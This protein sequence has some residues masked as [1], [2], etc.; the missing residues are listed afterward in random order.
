MC[1]F[2]GLFIGRKGHLWRGTPKRSSYEDR[3]IGSV[4]YAVQDREII[5]FGAVV[6]APPWATPRFIDAAFE[7][8]YWMRH[9]YLPFINNPR[10]SDIFLLSAIIT[11]LSSYSRVQIP[12]EMFQGWIYGFDT[13]Q[14]H[15]PYLFAC[16]A[17]TQ[18]QVSEG[19]SFFFVSYCLKPYT[20]SLHR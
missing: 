13:R 12:S 9:E 7:C 6:V 1:V 11:P 10:T 2:D 3:V 5:I 4:I 19:K 17:H 14:S 15:R 16:L 8:I 18:S 20:L